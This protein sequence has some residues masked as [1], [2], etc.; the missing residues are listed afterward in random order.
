MSVSSRSSSTKLS[1]AAQI[2]AQLLDRVGFAGS[3]AQALDAAGQLGQDLLEQFLEEVL[4]VLEVEIE[5]AAGDP[6]AR[7][8]V[9]HVGAMISLAGEYPLRVAQ[10]LRAPGLTFH[11]DNP[12]RRPEAN[13]RARHCQTAHRAAVD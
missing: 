2:V 11:R 9:G 12:C 6:R 1:D 5:G 4:L 13:A 3:D 10:H 7:D 8:D